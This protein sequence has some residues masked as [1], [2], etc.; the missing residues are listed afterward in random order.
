MGYGLGGE[1]M[2]GSGAMYEKTSF[3]VLVAVL[4]VFAVVSLGFC[5]GLILVRRKNNKIQT[6][7]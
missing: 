2:G 5:I 7:I 3:I 1:G 6:K 4:A